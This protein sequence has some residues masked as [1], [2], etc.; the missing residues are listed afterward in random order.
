MMTKQDRVLSSD[1]IPGPLN[2]LVFEVARRLLD[3]ATPQHLLLQLQLK[4]AVIDHVT[5]TAAGLFA[6]FTIDQK[7]ELVEPG[8]MIGGEVLVQ[9][10]GLD[11]PAGSLI[12]VGNGR[13]EYL[14][15]FTYGSAEWPDKPTV[16]SVTLVMP[17]QVP[18]T[19]T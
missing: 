12:K 14:E 7:A 6:H 4:S 10:D 8:E 1:E 17:L 9:A 13:I 19:A 2:V 18:A 16:R 11:A 5:L 15:I 3:G